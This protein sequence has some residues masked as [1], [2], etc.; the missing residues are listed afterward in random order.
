MRWHLACALLSLSLATAAA[1]AAE[2]KK[3]ATANDAA[4]IADRLLDRIDVSQRLEKV[5]FRDVLSLLHEK[6]GLTYLIDLKPLRD[7]GAEQTVDDA[8]VTVPAMKNVRAETVLRHVLDQLD[9][10]FY[11]APDHVQITTAVVKD[12]RTGNARPLPDLYA[13][14]GGD[15][16]PQVERKEV[17]RNTPFV[18]AAFKDTPAADALKDVAA[19]AGRTVVV[20]GPAAERAAGSVSLT[21][22]N[23]PFETATAALAEAVGLRAFRTGNVV[24]IVTPDRARQIEAPP[25]GLAIGQPIPE[26]RLAT[27]EQS[28]RVRQELSRADDERK[29]LEEKVKKLTEELEKLKKK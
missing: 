10:D 12:T 22:A 9:L 8:A 1:P 17:I 19:R 25:V 11:I 26:S 20:S 3:P 2:P 23:V 18:T 4:Q 13:G 29:A 16:A 15:D 14:T 21:L 27:P 7:S 24:V 28:D 6:T 5:P